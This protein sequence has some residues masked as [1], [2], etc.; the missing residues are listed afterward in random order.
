MS[1]PQQGGGMGMMNPM[2]EASS[3]ELRQGG[4]GGMA[5]M[6]PMMGMGGMGMMNPMMGMGGYGMLGGGL[7]SGAYGVGIGSPYTS[8][9]RGIL[10][11]GKPVVIH[12][13]FYSLPARPSYFGKVAEV[14]ADFFDT[15]SSATM[16]WEW[17]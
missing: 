6:N 15:D 3:F 17:E 4:M 11:E 13:S 7:G 10:Q 8:T 2:M 14:T 12:P 16:G 5:M 9:C 1:Q